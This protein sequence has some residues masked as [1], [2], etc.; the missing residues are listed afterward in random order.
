MPS[1]GLSGSL[2]LQHADAIEYGLDRRILADRRVDHQM[3]AMPIRP[4]DAEVLLDEGGAVAVH[5]FGEVDGFALG[6]AGGLQATDFSAE[7][8]VDEIRERRRGGCADS[9]RSRDPR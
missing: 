6:L 9:R 7:R 2:L 8:G 3:K 1:P 4:F 5:G